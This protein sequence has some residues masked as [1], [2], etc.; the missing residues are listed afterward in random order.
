MP[1]EIRLWK[2]SP[3]SGGSGWDDW[4]EVN[5]IEMGS[6]NKDSFLNTNILDKYGTPERYYS[7]I[8]LDRDLNDDKNSNRYVQMKNFIWGIK[9]GDI[10]LAYKKGEIVGLGEVGKRQNYRFFES[11]H[12]K[13]IL[14]HELKNPF[15]VTK[16]SFLNEFFKGSR[17]NNTIYPLDDIKNEIIDLFNK[18]NPEFFKYINQKN[19]SNSFKD[20][21]LNKNQIILYGPPGTGKTYKSREFSIE[22]IEGAL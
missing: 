3:W 18:T 14:W 13:D 22:F 17:T 16:I 4:K 9:E 15:N 1:K 6:W 11:T 19:E 7:E 8:G 12:I 10:L 21:L 20:L 5:I 2:I